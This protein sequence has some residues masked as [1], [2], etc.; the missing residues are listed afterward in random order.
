MKNTTIETA[1]ALGGCVAIGLTWL[2]GICLTIAFWVCVISGVL[3]GLEKFG[4]I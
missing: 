4:V 1:G 2:L 3:W